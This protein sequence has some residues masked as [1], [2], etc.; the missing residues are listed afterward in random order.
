M[1]IEPGVVAIKGSTYMLY[2]SS[3]RSIAV[4]SSKVDELL[5]VFSEV[6]EVLKSVGSDPAKG[7]LFYELQVK[8]RASGGKWVLK[9][10]IKT[11]DLLGQDLLALPISFVSAKG[12]SKL[13]PMAPPRHKTSVDK[14][15]R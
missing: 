6:E 3:R 15:G 8:A 2:N 9:K 7:V 4:E 10:T 14:L 1:F 11:S 12:G 5:H 13:R